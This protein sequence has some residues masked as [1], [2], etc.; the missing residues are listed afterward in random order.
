MPKLLLITH[1]DVLAIAYRARFVREGFEIERCRTGNDALTAG[2]KWAPDLLL[3]DLTLPGLHGL[4][5]LKWLTDVPA[6]VQ[7]PVLLLVEHT[8]APGI[9][10]ECVFWGARSTIQ[11]DV[12]PLSEVVEHV[13]TLLQSPPVRSQ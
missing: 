12:A 7:V 2:R 8:I 4:D 9:L 1:D 6:L 5:V 11:K 3:L 10:E 13:R